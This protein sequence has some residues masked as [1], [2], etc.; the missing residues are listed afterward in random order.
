MFVVPRYNFLTRPV[1]ANYWSGGIRSQRALP[2][3]TGA[4]QRSGAECTTPYSVR[5]SHTIYYARGKNKM[6]TRFP[7]PGESL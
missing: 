4:Q 3:V 1:R 5:G 2:L 6:V 7:A